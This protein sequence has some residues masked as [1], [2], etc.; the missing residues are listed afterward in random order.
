MKG[1]NAKP[2]I[3]IFGRNDVLLALSYSGES[4]EIIALDRDPGDRSGGDD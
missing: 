3:G 2:H 4:E 1:S